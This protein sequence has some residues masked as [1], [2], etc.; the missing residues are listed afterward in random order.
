M[1][2]KLKQISN[3]FLLNSVTHAHIVISRASL[4]EFGKTQSIGDG[5]LLEG[6]RG[7][8]IV[9]QSSGFRYIVAG[10]MLGTTSS[11]ASRMAPLMNIL[12]ADEAI[13]SKQAMV[14][15]IS[16]AMKAM[17]W[18]CILPSVSE[19][20]IENGWTKCFARISDVGWL[21]YFI[22]TAI[23]LVIIEFGIYWMHKLMH[24]I[25]PLYKY[26]HSTHHIYNKQ[27][28]LSPFAGMAL[29]P[30]DGVLEAMPHVVALFVVPMHFTTHIG[31][32]FMDTLW[33]A[34]IHDCIHGQV[35]PVMGAGYHT[36]QHIDIIMV[37]TQYGWT[38]CLVLLVILLIINRMTRKCN[39]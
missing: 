27:N 5:G 7:G 30:L 24:D 32:L 33:T 15:Q 12:I 6:V 26:L 21:T 20:L 16:V 14:L 3:P 13:L 28:T 1:S 23:Y 36:I 18:Y 34:N 22:N 4:P 38:G 35:W 19:Y 17:P 11:L 31:L 39:D 29:H 25:K 10:I 9:L 8:D 2:H 37:I